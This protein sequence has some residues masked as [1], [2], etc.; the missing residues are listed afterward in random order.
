MDVNAVPI[1]VAGRI[2]GDDRETIDQTH[3]S[4]EGH[5]AAYL[6]RSGG[7]GESKEVL[8]LS[9]MVNESCVQL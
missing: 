5:P 6:L 7:G 4:R 3:W 1:M 9:L 2:C 8:A